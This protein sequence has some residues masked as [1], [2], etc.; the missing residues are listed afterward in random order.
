LLSITQEEVLRALTDLYRNS[1]SP[2]KSE[3]IAKHIEK[4]EGTV[5][6]QMM[7]LRAL[8]LVKSMAGPRG[9]YQPTPKAFEYLSVPE[10][11]ELEITSMR[12]EDTTIGVAIADIDLLSMSSSQE[13]EAEIRLVEGYRGVS[14][15]TGQTVILGPTPLTNLIIKGAII[16]LYPKEN[17]ILLRITGM[18]SLPDD[19]AKDLATQS[20]I[21]ITP[22]TSILEAAKIFAE[23]GIRSLPILDNEGH[24]VCLFTTKN[25]AILAVEGKLNS[26]VVE[27]YLQTSQVSADATF[28]DC[29]QEMDR[30]GRGRLLVVDDAK[31][32]IGIITRT[33]LLHRLLE[34]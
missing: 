24:I 23:E 2:V 20:V 25:L 6:N 10:S 22:S 26:T 27:D 14:L 31:K 13:Q 30:I 8:R 29:L 32:L 12:V 9:G 3:E 4:H 7:S 5:R 33:D 18:L 15:A 17:K 19:S 16:G 1:S 34:T 11:D 21:T 28:T